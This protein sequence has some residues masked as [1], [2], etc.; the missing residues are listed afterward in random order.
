MSDDGAQP[1]LAVRHAMRPQRHHRS[2]THDAVTDPA[3][4]LDDGAAPNP[5]EPI[6]RAPALRFL[7]QGLGDLIKEP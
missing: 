3:A 6:G 7:H 2:A 5:P 1:E 4:L